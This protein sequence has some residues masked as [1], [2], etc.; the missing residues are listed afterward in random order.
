VRALNLSAFESILRGMAF[1]RRSDAEKAARKQR[2]A[3]FRTD[4]ESKREAARQERRAAREGEEEKRVATLKGALGPEEVVVAI[5]KTAEVLMK[6]YALFTDRR[7]LVAPVHAPQTPES[8]PY[9]SITGFAAANF[10]TKD[11]KLRVLSRD[12][13]ELQFNTAEERD[14]ALAILNERA[15]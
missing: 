10:V 15:V 8:I 14:Q 9:R 2:S 4:F 1:R 12:G 7:L 13:L 11:I 3:E 5:F 6:K